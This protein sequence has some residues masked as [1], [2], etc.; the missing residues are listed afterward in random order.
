MMPCSVDPSPSLTDS[1]GL[2]VRPYDKELAEL[3]R[4]HT[5]RLVYSHHGGMFDRKVEGTKA[6]FLKMKEL[7][8]THFEGYGTLVHIGDPL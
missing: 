4:V 1:S 2:C 6:W 3:N 8:G 7:V 5:W